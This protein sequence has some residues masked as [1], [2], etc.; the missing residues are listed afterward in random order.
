[1]IVDRGVHVPAGLVVG[2]DAALDAQRVR[3]TEKGSVLVTQA[4]I[5]R[6]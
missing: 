4:M 5:D 6:L 1:M 2:E 3:R